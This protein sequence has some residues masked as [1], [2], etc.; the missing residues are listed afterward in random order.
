[1]IILGVDPGS[2]ITGYGV[3]NKQGTNLEFV[4]CGVIKST[5]THPFPTRIKELHDGLSEVIEKFQPQYASVED[6]FLARNAQSA[7]KLGQARGALLVAAL[8]AGLIVHE[9]SAKQVKQ[10]VAGY[11]QAGKAQIQS[12]VR[13]MLKLTSSPSEDAADALAN[14]ICLANHL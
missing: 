1:M 14:A 12:V 2:R 11:G 9:F 4:S 5:P 8:S 13:M 10:T 3:I 6:V 7:L